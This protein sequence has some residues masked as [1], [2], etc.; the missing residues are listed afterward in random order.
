MPVGKREL[1]SARLAVVLVLLLGACA[2][3]GGSG[4]DPTS[5]VEVKHDPLPT[6]QPTK[7][8]FDALVID[9]AAHLLYVANR[10]R[11]PFGDHDEA[12][13]KSLKAYAEKIAERT[14]K[15]KEKK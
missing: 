1:V 12:T 3:F 6:V 14:K 5:Q 9:P 15:G 7:P 10:P 11:R 8:S 13:R 2:P 4:C